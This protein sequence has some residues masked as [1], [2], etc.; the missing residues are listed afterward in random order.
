MKNHIIQI[1]LSII[2]TVAAL[3]LGLLFSIETPVKT[4]ENYN[5]LWVTILNGLW[6]IPYLIYYRKKEL[7]KN[8]NISISIFSLVILPF[9]IIRIYTPSFDSE[10]WK[11]SINKTRT[12][13]GTQA[14]SQ[15]QMVQ[16][17]IDSEILL[18]KTLSEIEQIIG[19]NHFTQKYSDSNTIWYFYQS[20]SFFDGCDKVYIEF[21]KELSTKAGIGECD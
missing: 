15:G 17:L 19:E 18:G 9:L 5:L 1:L 21:E 12:Y 14:Y 11:N 20:K 6:F 13:G 3:F 2:L 16:D 4:T 7:K 8:A 10:K